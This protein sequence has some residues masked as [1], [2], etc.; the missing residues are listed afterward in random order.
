M[1]LLHLAPLCRCCGAA[2]REVEQPFSIDG[3]NPPASRALRSRDIYNR[4]MEDQDDCVPQDEQEI[5]DHI[6]DELV[7][8]ELMEHLD[9][10]AVGR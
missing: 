4:V 6:D 3:M 7:N 1:E 8:H 2:S 9:A 10:L 5:R